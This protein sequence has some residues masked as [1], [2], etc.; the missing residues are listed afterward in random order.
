MYIYTH[1]H[2]GYY[3]AIKENEI[4]PSA[5]ARMDLETVILS[6]V[7]HRRNIIWHSLCVELK[8]NNMQNVLTF[9]ISDFAE[10]PSVN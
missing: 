10:L 1:T 5:A 8:Q 2:H 3:S 9:Q 4:M 7:S 6:E